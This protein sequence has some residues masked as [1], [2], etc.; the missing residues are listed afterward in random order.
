MHILGA[1]LHVLS[2]LTGSSHLI[3]TTALRIRYEKSSTGS[4]PR[5]PWFKPSSATCPV[6]NFW[7]IIK[8]LSGF[9]LLSNK[10]G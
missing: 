8:P 4:G 1:R 3:T 5:L 6:C 7:Q 10:V 9:I 2:T